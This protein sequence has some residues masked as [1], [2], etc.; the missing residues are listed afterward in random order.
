[1]GHR[2]KPLLMVGHDRQQRAVPLITFTCL[3]SG[4]VALA[5]FCSQA[6]TPPRA[7]MLHGGRPTP[8]I[9]CKARRKEC[10][11][12]APA[13]RTSILSLIVI[14]AVVTSC[15]SSS[16]APSQTSAARR[17]PIDGRILFIGNSLTEAN[18]LPEVVERCRARA[19]G[20]QSTR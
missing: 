12:L 3:Q 2:G 6:T 8:L 15:S 7:P 5:C 4:P 19:G 20:R 17:A 14:A 9:G 1:M 13:V 18:G 11:N 10:G 16:V